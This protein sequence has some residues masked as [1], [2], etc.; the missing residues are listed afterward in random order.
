ME[1]HATQQPTLA[2]RPL[3]VALQP[4]ASTPNATASRSPAL[5]PSATAQTNISPSASS[6]PQPPF[7]SH[8]RKD[9][10]IDLSFPM[11]TTPVFGAS[12]FA[13]KPAQLDMDPMHGQEEAKES[14]EQG[15]QNK[16]TT[17]ESA[18]V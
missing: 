5:L 13:S 9:A 6:A 7:A 18:R 10:R 12:A 8:R 3:Q 15:T 16:H 17:W 4:R 14:E 11:P 2:S 1:A